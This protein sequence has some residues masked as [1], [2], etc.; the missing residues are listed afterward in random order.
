MKALTAARIAVVSIAVACQA[1]ASHFTEA[2]ARAVGAVFDS[3]VADINAGAWDRWGSRF[4]E[5]AT[6]HAAN[7]APMTGRAAIIA[8][9]KSFPPLESFSFGTAEVHGEGN[10]AYGS[11]PVYLKMRDIPA[12]TSKQLVVLRRGT[13]GMWLVQAVSVNT[14]LPLPPPPSPPGK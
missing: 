9:G 7:F 10:L 1:P 8:W 3:V 5:D 13:D 6:F 11:S 4:A 2:D 14:N 12:D